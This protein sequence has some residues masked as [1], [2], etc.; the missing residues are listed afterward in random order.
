MRDIG[1]KMLQ[2]EDIS[3]Y[4]MKRL[5]LLLKILQHE[6]LED[7]KLEKLRLQ[8]TI[9]FNRILG[10]YAKGKMSKVL[11]M[12]HVKDFLKEWEW[13]KRKGVIK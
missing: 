6:P 12:K 8:Q 7:P 10:E 13:R 5:Q 2:I 3:S 4:V 9:S 11:V 1:I